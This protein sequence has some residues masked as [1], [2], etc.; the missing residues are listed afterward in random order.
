MPAEHDRFVVGGPARRV[1]ITCRGAALRAQREVGGRVELPEFPVG[2][3][4]RAS[5]SGIETTTSSSGTLPGAM[6][7]SARSR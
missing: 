2:E 7:I 1:T 5:G 4:K 3:Q 6:V